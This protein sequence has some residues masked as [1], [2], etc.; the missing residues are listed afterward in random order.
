MLNSEQISSCAGAG[1]KTPGFIRHSILFGKWLPTEAPNKFSFHFK[2]LNFSLPQGRRLQKI[3]NPIL[4][5]LSQSAHC[6]F[7]S[8][9]CFLLWPLGFV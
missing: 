2:N 3:P 1:D 4:Q 7:I 8:Y 6:C 9:F 5:V